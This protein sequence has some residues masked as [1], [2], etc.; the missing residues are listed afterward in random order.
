MELRF[1]YKGKTYGLDLDD[2]L[3]VSEARLIKQY[4]GMSVTEFMEG[5]QK[6]D[7]DAI[8]G[9]VLLG[10][11]RGGGDVEWSDLDELDLIGLMQSMSDPNGTPLHELAANGQTPELP[12]ALNR[13]ARRGATKP[14][15]ATTTNGSR[16][17]TKAPARKRVAAR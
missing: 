9:V 12:E 16:S 11:R 4:T 6:A 15:P 2:Q 17:A 3:P 10:V 8:C 5:F 14:E 13:A 1:D 7:V